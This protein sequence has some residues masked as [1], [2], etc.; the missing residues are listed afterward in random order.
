MLSKKWRLDALVGIG[1]MAAVYAATHRNGAPCAIKMLHPEVSG[2]AE[3]RERFLREAYIGNKVGHPNVIQVSD[4]DVDEDGCAFLVMELLVGD[5][6]EDVADNNGGSL[7]ADDTLRICVTVLDALASAHDHEIVHRDIKPDNIFICKDGT[8][9]VLDF[10]IARLRE[11]GKDHTA[12]GML[13][14]TPAYMSPEQALGRQS[15]IGSHSDIFSV[16]AMIFKLLSGL[17]VHEG[18]SDGEILVAAATRPP[19]SLVTVLPGSPPGLTKIVDKMLSYDISQRYQDCRDVITD[20]KAFLE[21][22]AQAA[23]AGPGCGA[24]EA[25]STAVARPS[26][27][28]TSRSTTSA[29]TPTTSASSPSPGSRPWPRSTAS[30]SST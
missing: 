5:S 2:I 30:R 12:T 21:E 17:R 20:I 27:S 22:R 29:S 15:D 10:G 26:P 11:A 28:T 1:G 3:V 8:V 7:P 6:L 24:T 14:G 13:M 9:K 16:G 4:D 25:P 18:D 19:R 23:T